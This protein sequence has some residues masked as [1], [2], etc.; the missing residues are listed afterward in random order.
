MYSPEMRRHHYSY[1]QDFTV[2]NPGLLKCVRSRENS[3]ESQISY[4]LSSF[5]EKYNSFA[6]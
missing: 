2:I 5:P 3:A 1:V 6:S 4:F